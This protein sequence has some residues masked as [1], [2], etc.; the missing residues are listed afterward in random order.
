M[1]DDDP[2]AS[3]PTQHETKHCHTQKRHR[4]VKAWTTSAD[5]VHKLKR[6]QTKRP[7]KRA[8]ERQ[9]SSLS[10][11]MMQWL[12]DAKEK[13]VEPVPNYNLP[14]PAKFACTSQDE[15]EDPGGSIAPGLRPSQRWPS[16]HGTHLELRSWSCA[17]PLQQSSLCRGFTVARFLSQGLLCIYALEWSSTPAIDW[18]ALLGA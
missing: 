7:S 1:I 11:G 10:R 17:Q 14:V 16:S 3:N 15:R 9:H 13:D 12:M 2:P 4:S 8:L 6:H 18:K 5:P